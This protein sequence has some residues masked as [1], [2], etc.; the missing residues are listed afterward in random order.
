MAAQLKTAGLK[1]DNVKK[2]LRVL[3]TLLSE[4]VEDALIE[5]NPAL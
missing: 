3:S 5:A 2:H 4:A 1:R